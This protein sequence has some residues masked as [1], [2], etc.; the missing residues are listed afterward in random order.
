VARSAQGANGYDTQF[1][2]AAIAS[3]STKASASFGLYNAAATGSYFYVISDTFTVNASGGVTTAAGVTVKSGGIAVSSG[4]VALA[5][6]SVTLQS[7]SV[8]VT[9][10]SL[11]TDNGFVRATLGS[12][13]VAGEFVTVAATA[14]SPS[15]AVN[16]KV[17]GE[18]S[19]LTGVRVEATCTTAGSPVIG[20]YVTGTPKQD[21]A[22]GFFSAADAD[23]YFKGNVGINWTT[24]TVPLEVGGAARIRGALETTGNITSTGTAHSFA[25]GSIPASA[26]SGLSAPPTASAV[27]G[28]ALTATGAVG[29]STSY[30]RADHSH[31]FPTAANVGALPI[32]GGTLTGGLVAPALT[33]NTKR[34]GAA[35]FSMASR[36]RAARSWGRR[37][38]GSTVAVAKASKIRFCARS[39]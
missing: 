13:G 39:T 8:A 17:S 19:D 29:V 36:Q 28:A 3:D 23:N 31:P 15:Y 25:N 1:A 22:Y 35:S 37:F 11:W 18:G 14:T 2:F 26:I 16:A 38:D 10:G 6:G 4:N 32:G 34:G 21:K 9:A 7:G 12:S 27:V 30:A 20:V 24:P 33:L 5:N